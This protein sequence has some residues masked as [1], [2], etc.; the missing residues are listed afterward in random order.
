[1]RTDTQIVLW[2]DTCIQTRVPI[3]MYHCTICVFFY[4][5]GPLADPSPVPLGKQS[6]SRPSRHRVSHPSRCTD[7]SIPLLLKDEP[8]RAGLHL[9]TGAPTALRRAKDN[10]IPPS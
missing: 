10:C 6:W 2:G 9:R 5:F 1:M 7:S 4:S 3:G 8:R